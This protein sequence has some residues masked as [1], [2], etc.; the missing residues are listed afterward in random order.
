M[1]EAITDFFAE[2][3][4]WGMGVLAF[5]SGSIVPIA[6]ELLL[7]MFLNLGLDPVALVLVATVGNTLG[8]FTCY[9]LGYLTSKERVQKIF[10]ISNKRMKRADLLIQKYGYWTASISFVPAIGE[11]LLVALG[12]MRV[13]K[14][15]V[16][17]VMALGKLIR[18]IFIAA[19]FMGISSV[20]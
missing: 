8:G 9:L 4:Y 10:K 19:S 14:Y 15:K 20:L 7:A 6:S 16:L 5:L 1:V 17:A 3:G 2:Y 11:V 18:Y 12:V 13:D